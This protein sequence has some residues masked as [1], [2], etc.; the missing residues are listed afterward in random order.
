M[1]TAV[2]SSVAIPVVTAV[3]GTAVLSCGGAG[4]ADLDWLDDGCGD[5]HGV[6][7]AG[8]HG[9]GPQRKGG[10]QCGQAEARR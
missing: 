8:P 7:R 9:R 10:Q 6:R 4:D 1:S 2:V 5:R 3:E